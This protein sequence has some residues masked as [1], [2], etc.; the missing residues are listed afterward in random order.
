VLRCEPDGAAQVLTLLD[1]GPGLSAERRAA[2]G[3]QLAQADS[4]T[5]LG[6][7]LAAL[8]AGAHQ[9]RLLLCPGGLGAQ[10]FG[11]SLRLWDSA[12]PPSPG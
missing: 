2:L 3:A 7:R 12:A 11:V 9:G 4:E 8:V 10:G 1:D 6:L 5:G